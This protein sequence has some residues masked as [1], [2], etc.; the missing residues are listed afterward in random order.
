MRTLV[1]ASPKHFFATW[2][3]NPDAPPDEPSRAMILGS[4]AHHLLLG[5]DAFST[6]YIARPD[7]LADEWGEMKPWQGNRKVCKAWLAAQEQAGRIVLTS[8]ELDSIKGMARELAKTPEVQEGLLNGL[9]EH[10]LIWRDAETGL[11]LRARPDVIP[12]DSGMFADLKTIRDTSIPSISMA[13]DGYDQQAA[14]VWEGA[15]ALGLEVESFTFLFVESDAPWDV[16]PI[17]VPDEDLAEARR[18]NR[19]AIQMIARCIEKGEWPGRGYGDARVMGMGQ[20]ARERRA[21]RVE[22]IET[23]LGETF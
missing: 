12:T 10:S 2:S 8:A 21:K 5:E 14:L 4:A 1:E 20:A 22:F 16:V 3:G 7:E 17:V 18:A 15:E 13:M 6:L 19:A 11:W 9:V 23:M